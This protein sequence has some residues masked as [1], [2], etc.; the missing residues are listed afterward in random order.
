[1]VKLI[2]CAT[3][4]SDISREEFDSYWREKHGPL[5]NFTVL[6]NVLQ[7]WSIRVCWQA[8]TVGAMRQG[9]EQEPGQD[10]AQASNRAGLMA[11]RP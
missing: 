1:M 3:R 4:R 10:N 6:Q 8:V 2:I 5:V 7:K 9:A 11:R